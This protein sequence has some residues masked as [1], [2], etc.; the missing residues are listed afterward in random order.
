MGTLLLPSRTPLP[1]S[2]KCCP[3]F[4]YPQDLRDSSSYPLS[5]F[6]HHSSSLTLSCKLQSQLYLAQITLLLLSTSTFYQTRSPHLQFPHTRVVTFC[7]P[8]CSA[9]FWLPA[10]NLPVYFP[11]LPPS[12]HTIAHIVS[13]FAQIV[14]PPQTC[15]TLYMSLPENES[16]LSQTPASVDCRKKKPIIAPVL[17]PMPLF[18]QHGPLF[19]TVPTPSATQIYEITITPTVHKSSVIDSAYNLHFQHLAEHR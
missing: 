16:L 9:F 4:R 7:I 3:C 10:L 19:V 13:S 14:M 12:P 5:L 15:Q 6:H 1:T 8:H 18:P 11:C 17:N 2:C